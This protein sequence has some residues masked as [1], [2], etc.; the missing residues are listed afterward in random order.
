MCRH[1]Y[2]FAMIGFSYQKVNLPEMV[3]NN[4]IFHNEKNMT[5]FVREPL[6]PFFWVL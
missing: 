5:V 2:S 3:K 4:R 1:L 6:Y